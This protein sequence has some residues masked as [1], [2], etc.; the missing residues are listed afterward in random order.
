MHEYVPPITSPAR[1][2]ESNVSESSDLHAGQQP[3]SMAPGCVMSI[4]YI[5]MSQG[6]ASRFTSFEAC[7]RR[8]FRLSSRIQSRSAR[9]PGIDAWNLDPPGSRTGTIV[10]ARLR[11]QKC[12]HSHRP[13]SPIPLGPT[14][15]TRYLAAPRALSTSLGHCVM[16]SLS[17]WIE[18]TQWG[19]SWEDKMSRSVLMTSSSSFL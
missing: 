12:L 5:Q 10:A 14:A 16:S 7:S 4:P 9:A 13:D 15:T 17:L 3:P 6:P 8:R 11:T 2:L 19:T 1:V 18:Y